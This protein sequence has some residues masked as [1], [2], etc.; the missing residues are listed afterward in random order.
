MVACAALSRAICTLGELGVA[1]HMEPSAPQRVENLAQLTR[2]HER[3]LYRRMR[4]ASSYEVFQE[5]SHREFDHTP[6]SAALST[7]AGR[8]FRP[9]ARMFH[10]IFAGWDGLT[11]LLRLSMAAPSFSTEKFAGHG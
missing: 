5:T 2:S 7:D 6:L 4:F 3:S 8:S 10:H 1:D 9:A 11:T